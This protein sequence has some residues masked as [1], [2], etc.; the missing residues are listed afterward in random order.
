MPS[1]FNRSLLALAGLAGAAGVAAAAGASHLGQPP[2]STAADFLLF[3]AAALIGISLLANRLAAIAGWVLI[4]G[5]VLF[6]GDLTLLSLGG[7][8]PLPIMAPIGGGL[9]ILGWLLLAA[10]AFTGRSGR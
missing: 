6:A 7:A 2:L 9:L 3:H 4:V 10:S 8:S 5:L 1:N